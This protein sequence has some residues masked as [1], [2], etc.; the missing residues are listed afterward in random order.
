MKVLVVSY[1]LDPRLGGGAATTALHLCQGLVRRGIEVVA[2]TT[3]D[4]P[5]SRVAH[6][7]GMKLYSFRPKNLYWVAEKSRQPLA[8]K[9]IW[10]LIDTWNPHVYNY[11][12]QIIRREAPDVV[13]VNKLRGLSPSVWA[14]AAAE[15]GRPIVQSCHDYEIISPEG[16]LESTVG[17]WALARH[18]S[19]RPYQALRSRWSEKV[20][21]VTSPSRFTLQT[22][23]DLGFFKRSRQLVVPNSHGFTL[24]ELRRLAPAR[25]EAQ[26]PA[27]RLNIL[28]LGRL[29]SIKGIDILCEA[30]AAIAPELPH[31]RLDIAGS[32]SREASLRESYGGLAQFRFHGHVAGPAKEKLITEADVLVMPSIWQEVFGIS[33]IEAYAYGKPVIASRIGGMPELVREGQTGLLVEPG[34]V[35]ALQDA[36]RHL[37]AT[38]DLAQAMS[39]ACR[40]AARA[41]TLEAVIEAYL[42]AY[43]RTGN[44]RAEATVPADHALP[45][46]R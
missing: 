7:D 30:Y 45:G 40:E 13:H 37:A 44:H 6:Q 1:L 28:Y 14:A 23:T 8:R 10:Q 35:T 19:V 27:G 2:I 24:E 42:D 46:E 33:I 9:V 3:H 4:E 43:G 36:I 29:E 32:G 16:S 21:V 17:R 5:E 25:N 38:P 22:I 18:W 11:V 12:R 41:Y 15:N 39:P 31:T 26:R 34:H 20:D